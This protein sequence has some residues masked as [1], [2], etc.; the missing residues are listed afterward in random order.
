MSRLR[1]VGAG[2]AVAL[3]TA[4][5]AGAGGA[6]AQQPPETELIQRIEALMPEYEA[7]QAARRD[8]RLR[9]LELEAAP[10][11]PVLRTD[12]AQVG[13]MRVVSSPDEIGLARELFGEVWREDFASV[14]E[15]P[16]LRSVTFVFQWRAR[17][18][19]VEVPASPE[20]ELM[21]VD[22]SRVWAPTRDHAKA[23]IANSVAR[24]LSE[25]FPQG[26]PVRFWLTMQ[27]YPPDSDIYRRLATTNLGAGAECLSGNV[28]ACEAML[29]FG[30]ARAA[31]QLPSWFT[32]DERR[33]M[34]ERAAPGR[35]DQDGALY[36]R[37]VEE[38][39]ARACDPLL[40]EL[41]WVTW[42]PA[43]DRLRAH[44]LWYAAR[45][46]SEPAWQNALS[47][48]EAPM[49]EALASISGRPI[50]QL[51]ADWRA[52]VVAQRPDVHADLGGRS[53]RVLLWSLIFAALAMRSSRWRMA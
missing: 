9:E 18:R 41:D 14:T 52:Y 50:E 5:A 48:R 45:V 46:G 28:L 30:L 7:A 6:T 16:S 35:V 4:L 25:D 3:A 22:V 39:D 53:T 23:E 43:S 31:D 38:D 11:Q 17:L 26:S 19:S 32:R 10:A 42:T 36:R 37:C 15:S 33:E 24:A 27:G 34:V 2:W 8:A 29:G 21:R 44:V 20:A 13:P 40:S 12:T 47:S 1:R 49:H 51:V